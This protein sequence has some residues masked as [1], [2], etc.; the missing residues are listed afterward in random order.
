MS[1][2]R[3]RSPRIRLPPLGL[4]LLGPYRPPSPR[5]GHAISRRASP[6]SRRR[7]LCLP[8]PPLVSLGRAL[9][10]ANRG[11]WVR[12]SPRRAAACRHGLFSLGPAC[13]PYRRAVG[14]LAPDPRRPSRQPR[15]GLA[16]LLPLAPDPAPGR[17]GLRA[18]PRRDLL[19]YALR[20]TVDGPVY[21]GQ[22]GGRP[23]PAVGMGRPLGR[24]PPPPKA[25]ASSWASCPSG[26]FSAV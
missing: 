11:T 18:Q 14:G 22:F 20:G 12:A 16:Y 6:L 10:L 3:L 1:L 23:P 25:R 19:Q 15:P 4:G 7:P 2:A 26:W 8:Q 21:L 17:L 13:R 24:R 9:V 5:L